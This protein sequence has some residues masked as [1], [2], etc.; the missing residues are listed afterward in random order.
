M[1][2]DLLLSIV[3]LAL[4]YSLI[5]ND[6]SFAEINVGPLFDLSQIDQP[7]VMLSLHNPG[8]RSGYCGI[9]LESSSP[10]SMALIAPEFGGVFLSANP[11]LISCREGLYVESRSLRTTSGETIKSVLGRLGAS[12]FVYGVPC[13]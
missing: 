3:A 12:L 6:T 4:S 9:A 11:T 13:K 5:A 2:K 10:S 1:K 8:R 7:S